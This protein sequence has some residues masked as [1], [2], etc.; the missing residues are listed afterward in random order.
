MLARHLLADS[1][2]PVLDLVLP[3][4]CPACGAALGEQSG[5]CADCFG[6]LLIPGNPCC[7]SCQRPFPQEGPPDGSLCAPCL[8]QPPRHAGIAAGTLYGPVSRDLLLKFKH[9][10]RIALAPMLSRM[11][12]ARLGPPDSARVI[13]PVP[14]HRWRLWKR[15]YNQAALLA[16]ELARMGH[17]TLVVDALERTRA[18]P[19]LGHLGAVARRKVL[20]GA[21][22]AATRRT[23]AIAGREVILVDDVMTSGATTDACVRVLRRA[24]ARSVRIA[25]FARVL[26]E[27]TDVAR[28]GQEQPA[29]QSE[30]PEV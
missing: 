10:R 14:L 29:S 3:P 24:G 5:L 16:G 15:G 19:S 9:G 7:G 20:K 2:R 28:K 1:L 22:V 21:I 23:A 6:Q 30:T 27:A 12:S 4:R 8:A 25:C 11:M 18:T 17:G 13:V 26:D